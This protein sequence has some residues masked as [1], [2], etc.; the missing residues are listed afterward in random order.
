MTEYLV[1]NILFHFI[2]ILYLLQDHLKLLLHHAHT[3][4]V[5]RDVSDVVSLNHGAD[6]VAKL[7]RTLRRAA[8]TEVEPLVV[9]ENEPRIP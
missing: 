2:Y 8:A 7:I 4:C 6:L 1:N 5:E 3:L 9:G